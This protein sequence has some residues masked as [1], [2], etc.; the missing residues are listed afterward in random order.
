MTSS[1]IW[2]SLIVDDPPAMLPHKIEKKKIDKI[3]NEKLMIGTI[4]WKTK[5]K[6]K[7]HAAHKNQRRVK[8]SPF[9]GRKLFHPQ[10]F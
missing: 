8:A 1:Q 10:P 3:S 7:K 2:L 6:A 9:H 5:G 4:T